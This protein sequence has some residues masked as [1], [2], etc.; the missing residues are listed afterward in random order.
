MTRRRNWLLRGGNCVRHERAIGTPFRIIA[1]RMTRSCLAT[2]MRIVIGALPLSL[3]RSSKGASLRHPRARSQRTQIHKRIIWPKSY[4]NR[5]RNDS[6]ADQY[7]LRPRKNPGWTIYSAAIAE[8]VWPYRPSTLAAA[9]AGRRS[10][11]ECQERDRIAH[12]LHT[13]EEARSPN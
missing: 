11:L 7:E 6:L 12:K 4:Q 2:A 5:T 1:S 3:V 13:W 10:N 8:L 9:Q